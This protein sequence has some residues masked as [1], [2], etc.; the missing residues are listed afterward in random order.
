MRKRVWR[1]R[2]LILVCSCLLLTAYLGGKYVIITNIVPYNMRDIDLKQLSQD[3]DETLIKPFRYSVQSRSGPKRQ[4]F[5][6]D[7]KAIIEGNKTE[8]KKA[9]ALMA[10]KPKAT[11]NDSSYIRMT[12]DCDTFIDARGYNDQI[13]STEEVE[14]P[15]AYSL[16]LYQDVEQAERLLRAI[17]KPQNYYCIHV[18]ADSPRVVHDA[19]EGIAGCFDNVFVVT[20]KEYIVYAGFTRLQ[21]DLIACRIFFTE[22]RSG[23]TL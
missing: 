12:D 16:L 7:C 1:R 6:V 8:I 2:H 22:E 21:A 13:L 9:L 10:S 19:V 14:F 3:I 17:Y 11:V 18:D 20:R 4:V 5:E 23:N 15:I